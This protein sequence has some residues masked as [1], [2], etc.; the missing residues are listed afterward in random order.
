ME[1]AYGT[2][3]NVKRDN[4]DTYKSQSID[5]KLFRLTSE[6]KPAR[7]IIPEPI[8]TQGLI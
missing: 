5:S 6:I 7:S 8:N 2:N 3:K 1:K 4:L